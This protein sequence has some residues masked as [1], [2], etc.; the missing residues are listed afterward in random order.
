MIG[1]MSY[2]GLGMGGLSLVSFFFFLL[3]AALIWLVVSKALINSRK[4]RMM[5]DF[6]SY[7][8]DGHCYCECRCDCHKE[9]GK[10]R[11]SNKKTKEE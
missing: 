2:G 5:K 7:Y 8:R 9:E 11:K 6:P 1:P 3:I 10:P 4:Y